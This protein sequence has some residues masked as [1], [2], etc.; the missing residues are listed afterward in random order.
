[1]EVFRNFALAIWSIKP[2]PPPLLM[3]PALVGVSLM[4]VLAGAVVAP[5]GGTVV[6]F[7]SLA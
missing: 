6:V 7:F 3:P 2:P 4:G 5:A 1:M